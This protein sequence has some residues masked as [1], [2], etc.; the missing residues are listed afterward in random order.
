MFP[1]G[2]NSKE[3]TQR[4]ARQFANPNMP[5]RS[6]VSEWGEITDI[7]EIKRR[8][9]ERFDKSQEDLQMIAGTPEYVTER[10]KTIMNVL[11]PG[12]LSFW[13]DGPIPPAERKKCLRLLAHE[14]VPELRAHADELGLHDPFQRRPGSVP[15]NSSGVPEPVSFP[16]MAELNY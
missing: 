14:V 2:Y 11:R 16:E 12:I 15:L 8:I 5:G 7:A 9:Y 13:I 3:A 1:P 10:L 4:L 6:M